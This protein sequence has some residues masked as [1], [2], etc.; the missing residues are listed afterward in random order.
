MKLPLS[1][2]GISMP[3]DSFLLVLEAGNQLLNEY[4]GLNSPIEP[5]QLT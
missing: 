4:I 5:D 1:L 3:A 2:R